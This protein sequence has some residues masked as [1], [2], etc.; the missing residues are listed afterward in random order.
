MRPKTLVAACS[1]A[2]L[3]LSAGGAGWLHAQQNAAAQAP[4][5]NAADNAA[6]YSRRGAD[7]CLRCHDSPEVA[8]I[9]ETPH[10]RR[11]DARS[12]FSEIG[13]Q[14]EACH[15]PGNAHSGRV[16]PGQERPPIMDFGSDEPTPIA[17]QNAVCLDCHR[18]SVGLA[19][20]ASPHGGDD[21]ACADCHRVHDSH[22]P[23]MSVAAQ[24]EV[25]Y[26]C[27]KRQR[28][29]SLKASVHP[30]RDEQMSCTGCH[31]P[32]ASTNEFLLVRQTINDTCFGCH[33]EKRGP[34]LWEHAPVAEDCSLCHESHGSNHP[35]LLTR[36]APLLCQQCHSQQGHPS[37]ARTGRGLAGGEPSAFLLAQ[38]CMNCHTQVHGSN[39]PSG[40]R[41]TR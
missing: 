2:L 7:G 38:S 31:E 24:P 4:A 21:L 20:H 23:V 1:C 22:D 39:H 40:P 37:V 29:D 17:E 35:A 36:R 8:A 28:A 6:E 12:P 3:L 19:W 27:H 33:A 16:R 18:T 32:H 10:G 14:C 41:L 15:G 34:F 25:C 26:T 11:G 9:F 5:D 13:L 30:V